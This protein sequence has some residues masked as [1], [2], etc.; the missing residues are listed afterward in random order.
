MLQMPLFGVV[1]YRRMLADLAAAGFRMRPT[2]DI[3]TSE[4]SVFMRH[5]VDCH[6]DGIIQFARLERELGCRS[7][8]FVPVTF[9]FNVL[10]KPNSD[11]LRELVAFG[12]NIGLHYDPLVTRTREDLRR[13]IRVLENASGFKVRSVTSHKPGSLESKVDTSDWRVPI[14]SEYVSDS[15]RRWRDDR[16]MRLTH[17]QTSFMLLTHVEHWMSA[18]QS[19]TGHFASSLLPS[20]TRQ[21]EAHAVEVLTDCL[22]H[23]A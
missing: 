3:G 9:N 20:S 15:G 10:H 1:G 5:D 23:D 21:A 19:L 6:L 13:Q 7:T 22:S 4:R 16:L 14:H 12:H 8:W 11:V 18:D 2:E 17:D